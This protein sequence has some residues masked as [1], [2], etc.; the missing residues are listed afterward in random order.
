MTHCAG[1]SPLL[2]RNRARCVSTSWTGSSSTQTSSPSPSSFISG[3]GPLS[4][5]TP[6]TPSKISYAHINVGHVPE[7]SAASPPLCR[8]AL[9]FPS[10]F[11][12]A[13]PGRHSRS[14]RVAHVKEEGEMGQYGETTGVTFSHASSRVPPGELSQVYVNSEAP[15]RRHRAAARNTVLCCCI[16]NKAVHY[17]TRASASEVFAEIQ[18]WEQKSAYGFQ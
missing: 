18:P 13:L 4:S 1:L 14:L 3:S 12:G 15:S 8:L 11:T 17:I 2:P 7:C 6:E 9:L 5:A 16:I 10:M